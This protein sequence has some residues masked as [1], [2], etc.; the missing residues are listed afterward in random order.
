MRDL[1]GLYELCLKA[2]GDRERCSFGVLVEK[3]KEGLEKCVE[4]NAATKCFEKCVEGCGGGED[5]V[6][7]C[8][9][10][11]DAA[12]ARAVAKDVLRGAVEAVAESGLTVTMPEAA[13]ALVSELLKKYADADC[14][15]RAVLFRA[16]S[17]VIVDLHNVV[18][19]DLILM[20][21]PLISVAY[22]CVGEAADSLLE[23]VRHAAGEEV[24][25]KISAA[26]DSGEVAV[27]R[28]LIRF[29]PVR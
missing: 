14:E 5:C 11:V 25:A 21:A 1:D 18:G 12:T 29:Q 8:Y 28:V 19:P 26:L 20:L 23:E 13:A 17:M 15:A 6:R 10:A 24:A 7:A 22:D 3:L 27:K 4:K 2:G 9:V 16:M